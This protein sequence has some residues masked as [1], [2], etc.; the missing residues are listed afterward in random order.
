MLINPL[1][2]LFISAARGAFR[3]QG[4]N[5]VA[6]LWAVGWLWD[7]NSALSAAM[8]TSSADV[9]HKQLLLSRTFSLLSVSLWSGSFGKLC[10]Q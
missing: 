7:I 3:G 10:D 2:G 5:P 9:D 4:S 8:K 1:V 6:V